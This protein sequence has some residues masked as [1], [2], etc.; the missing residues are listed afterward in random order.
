MF[1]D[2]SGHG[3]EDFP[4]LAPLELIADDLDIRLVLYG[5]AASR[6]MMLK[7]ANCS[8]DRAT[9]F[10]LAPFSSDFDLR[11]DGN[12]EKTF[13]LKKRIAEEIPFASWFRWSAL[14][15][16]QSKVAN[17]AR[18]KSTIVPL[19]R[20]EIGNRGSTRVTP[21]AMDDIEEKRVSFRRN[22]AFEQSEMAR[23]GRDVEFFGMMLAFYALLDMREI[24][25][26]GSL[27]IEEGDSQGWMS[28]SSL[29]RQLALFEDNP[30][31]AA[32]FWNMLVNLWTRAGFELA[33][34][35]PVLNSILGAASE[36]P[37]LASLVSSLGNERGLA[38]SRNNTVG[39][40]RVPSKIPNVLVGDEAQSFT[41]EFLASLPA[42]RHSDGESRPVQ[43]D[44]AF[45][46]IAAV[47]SIEIEPNQQAPSERDDFDPYYS[48][49]DEEFFELAWVPDGTEVLNPN[50][51]TA[52]VIPHPGPF[53]L[54]YTFDLPAVGG[55]F[56]GHRPWVRIR[57]DDL[58]Q[59]GPSGK[60]VKVAIL[61]LQVPPGQEK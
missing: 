53:E 28:S 3:F 46:L 18:S 50:G 47:P 39:D 37:Q 21:E 35:Y 17:L 22:P 33:E 5:G 27:T 31:L 2:P 12:R 43:L 1:F 40:L 9:L 19:R 44:P 56:P 8:P 4:A 29:K 34:E 38:T 11:H 7:I 54:P 13:E 23:K 6:A 41:E 45:D 30:L 55:V 58:I 25:G 51:I 20:I 14:D 24:F 48:A 59:H 60:A 52:C 57:L 15:A 32:R 36:S 10:D 49:A 26:S 16:E 61:I 42:S